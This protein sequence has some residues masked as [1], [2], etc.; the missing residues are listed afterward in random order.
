MG[1]AARRLLANGGLTIDGRASSTQLLVASYNTQL[2]GQTF[3][4][5][6]LGNPEP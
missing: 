2:Q 5:S 1:I 4:F 6:G 3:A